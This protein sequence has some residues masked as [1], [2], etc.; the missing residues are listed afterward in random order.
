ML[1]L[2]LGIGLGGIRTNNDRRLSKLVPHQKI[3]NYCQVRVRST[4][5]VRIIFIGY[6]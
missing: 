4:V 5:R 3:K 6:G 1:G 2:R